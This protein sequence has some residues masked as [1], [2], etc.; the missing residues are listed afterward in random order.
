MKFF[1][2][3]PL[4]FFSSTESQNCIF[5]QPEVGGYTCNLQIQNPSGNEIDLIGG[6]HLENRSDD[7]VQVLI[8][9]SQNTFNIPKILCYQ[10]RNLVNFSIINSQVNLVSSSSFY[11]CENIERISLI[12]NQISEIPGNSFSN[13]GNLRVLNL[14]GNRLNKLEENSLIGTRIEWLTLDLNPFEVFEGI[15]VDSINETLTSLDLMSTQLTEIQSNSFANLRN[16]KSLNLGVNLISNIANDAFLGLENLQILFLHG[17]FIQQ[18]RPGW[19]N[20]MFSLEELR[21]EFNLINSLPARIFANNN[22]L[23]DLGL[24]YNRITSVNRNA[25]G[26]LT[27]MRRFYGEINFINAIDPVRSL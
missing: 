12:N 18:L 24:S 16:L 6:N 9:T 15:W 11:Y 26:D 22:R 5:S 13:S 21:L 17:N 23:V 7:D 19:F 25:F 2:L 1:L 4:L 27:A 20:S 14:S 3:F 8:A 10:F